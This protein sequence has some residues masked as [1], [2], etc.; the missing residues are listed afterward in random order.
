MLTDFVDD[1]GSVKE[2]WNIVCTCW[3]GFVTLLIVIYDLQV[4]RI[5]LFCL[6]I[7][8]LL[9]ELNLSVECCSFNLLAGL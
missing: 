9:W 4:I 3:D 8:L 6:Q 1:F 2:L 7:L 5:T